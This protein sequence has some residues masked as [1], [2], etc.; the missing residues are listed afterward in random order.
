MR[1]TEKFNQLKTYFK[2][3]VPAMSAESWE[4]T[5]QVLTVRSFKKGEYLVREGEVCNYVSFINYGLVRMFY[6]ADDKEKVSMFANENTYISDYE[7][8]LT[9]QPANSFL[10]AMEPTEVVDIS[11]SDLQML[12]DKVPEANLLGRKIAENL[13][14]V[15]CEQ[16]NVKF[17]ETIAQRYKKLIAEMPWLMQRVPQYMIAS[18]LGITPEAFS[19]IKAKTSK[20]KVLVTSTY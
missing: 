11:F 3:L 6:V 5:E 2:Q 15:L 10:Q 18:Y 12:Y 14:I 19:R 9:R 13:F 7:S 8:F 4:I 17:K 16:S 1:D 20:A